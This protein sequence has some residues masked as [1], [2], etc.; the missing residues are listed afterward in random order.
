M[1]RQVAGVTI[2]FC[3]EE[4]QWRMVRLRK[5]QLGSG[6]IRILRRAKSEFSGM[7]KG[8]KTTSPVFAALRR[9]RPLSLPQAAE[10]ESA[11]RPEELQLYIKHNGLIAIQ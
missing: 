7:T 3:R 1:A 5:C 6:Q 8:G 2:L 9:G 10:R 11:E 4:I